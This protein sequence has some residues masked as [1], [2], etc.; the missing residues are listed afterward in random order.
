MKN[1]SRIF[2]AVL[3]HSLAT[4]PAYPSAV[5]VGINGINSSGLG[6]TGS[7]VGIGQLEFSRPSDNSFDTSA[8]LINS[9]VNPTQVYYIETGMMGGVSTAATMNDSDEMTEPSIGDTDGHAT[10]VASVIISPS[11]LTTGVAPQAMLHSGGYDAGFF[12]DELDA[13]AVA[14][15]HIATRNSGQIHAVN[16]SFGIEDTF[17]EGIPNGTSILSSFLDWSSRV[18]D[19]LYVTGGNEMGPALG[20]NIPADDFNG[21]TVAFS[22]PDG[23]G[24]FRRVHSGNEPIEDPFSDRTF[25]DILAPGLNIAVEALGN[26]TINGS[27]TS[28]AAPH[29]T[30]TVALL[31]QHGNQQAGWGIGY[32]RHE[33]MKAAIMNS[34][35]KV[36]G[37][38]GMT[39]TV[40]KAN[41]DTWDQ[42]P[43]ATDPLIP[44]D[45]D[46]GAGHLNASRALQQF[47][48]G[49]F[50]PNGAPVPVIGWDLGSTAGLDSVNKYVFDQELAGGS[51]ISITLAWDRRVEFSEDDG[52]P[53]VFD[54]GDAL[55]GPS[56]C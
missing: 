24:T 51:Y 53:G 5:S 38:L 49:E 32:K 2:L 45:E 14:G 10:Q 1:A 23:F 44:L 21:M 27:G 46:M 47:S 9:Q 56:R 29:V 54:S 35:D 6:L 55:S 52:T 7:G 39:R 33:V 31:Q 17:G 18:H 41:G 19:V 34:A 36:S 37:R 25:V 30:G 20:A 4:I 42:S 16:M 8:S 3:L 28:F 26:A 43:A 48:P 12:V 40:E 50:D 11:G 22:Q 15:Q 13:A